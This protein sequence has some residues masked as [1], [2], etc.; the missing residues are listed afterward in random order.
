MDPAFIVLIVLVLLFVTSIAA[1]ALAEASP[2]LPQYVN[3]VQ[4]T[5]VAVPTRDNPRL[6]QAILDIHSV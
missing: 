6:Q 5:V 1:F 4:P 2:I 3:H